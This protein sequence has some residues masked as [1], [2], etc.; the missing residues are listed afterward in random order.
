MA[1]LGPLVGIWDLH[2]DRLESSPMVEVAMGLDPDDFE[3]LDCDRHN[4]IMQVK[5]LSSKHKE[6]FHIMQQRRKVETV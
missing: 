6:V 2:D 1:I 5:G 4:M 3:L